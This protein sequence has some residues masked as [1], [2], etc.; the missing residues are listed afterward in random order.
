MNFEQIFSTHQDSSKGDWRP[1]TRS[2]LCLTGQQMLS[3]MWKFEEKKN[4]QINKQGPWHGSNMP[5]RSQQAWARHEPWACWDL[6][7]TTTDCW[8]VRTDAYQGGGVPRHDAR[9]QQFGRKYDKPLGKYKRQV[10]SKGLSEKTKHCSMYKV[11][12]SLLFTL[13]LF[14]SNITTS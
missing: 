3:T 2:F 5:T 1:R 10:F 9:C 13:V 11:L 12:S 6:C 8:W 7:P 4:R 14:T